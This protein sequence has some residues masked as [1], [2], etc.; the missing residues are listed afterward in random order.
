MHCSKVT[1]IGSPVFALTT[2]CGEA[3]TVSVLRSNEHII[4]RFWPVALVVIFLKRGLL[5]HLRAGRRQRRAM[6][7]A[8]RAA[9]PRRRSKCHNDGGY[10]L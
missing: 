7:A 3:R 4:H 10:F 9:P 1:D 2:S 6:N 5:T 8:R